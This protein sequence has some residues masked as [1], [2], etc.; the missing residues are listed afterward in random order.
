MSFYSLMH[1]DQI[2]VHAS[3]RKTLCTWFVLKHITMDILVSRID[4]F[5]PFI[6]VFHILITLE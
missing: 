5:F 6:K 1:P 4:R 2:S 3:V